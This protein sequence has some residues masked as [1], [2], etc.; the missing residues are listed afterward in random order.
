MR[1]QIYPMQAITMLITAALCL[2]ALG[3]TAQEVYADSQTSGVTGLCLL[4]GVISPGSAVNSN[5][6]DYALFNIPASL[7]MATVYQQ[8]AF[9]ITNGQDCDS[10]IIGIGLALNPPVNPYEQVTVQ[11]FNGNVSN[12][13]AQPVTDAILR[14]LQGYGRAEIVL[15]PQ[16]AFDRVKVTLTANGLGLLTTLRVYYA[17]RK[18]ALPPPQVTDSMAICRGATALLNAYAAPG[19]SIHW[20][21]APEGGQLLHSGDSYSVTPAATTT[22][23]V[24]AFE[25]GCSSSR[26]PATVIVNKLPAPALAFPPSPVCGSQ[27]FT[28]QNYQEGLSYPVRLVYTAA[29]SMPVMDSSWVAQGPGIIAPSNQSPHSIQAWV[30]VLAQDPAAGCQSDT[31]AGSF[32]AGGIGQLPVTADSDISIC[33]GSSVTLHAY[34]PDPSVPFIH[35]YDAPTGGQLLHTGD[36]FTVHPDTTTTYYATSQAQCEYP[37]RIAVKVTTSPRPPAPVLG[38]AD[39]IYMPRFSGVMLT[40]S[41]TNGAV[42]HWYRSDTAS[43]PLY[44]G[45]SYSFTALSTGTLYFY[46]GADLNGCESER[47]Q[48]TVIVYS[49]APPVMTATQAPAL[50]PA[51]VRATSALLSPLQVYPNPS[52]GEIRFT[53]GKDLSGSRIIIR[54]INGRTMLEQVLQRN[55]LDISGL[56]VSGVYFMQVITREGEVLTGKVLFNGM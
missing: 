19:S 22:Y 34:T 30:Y 28:I 11:T 47:K 6:E 21:D 53:A 14:Q 38:T 20:Y 4:C 3:S 26:Q 50:Q 27:P 51:P 24:E 52:S 18:P 45:E 44:T 17:Y 42:I 54:D 46:A 25:A 23:Y 31:A 55:G 32:T 35:W 49:G 37:Q 16:Q 7:G 56:P 36:Y 8:L 39:T 41:G 48:V 43:R 10:L 2:P 9:P 40:A 29:D 5:L 13:D 33:Q 12:E 1:I 15:K